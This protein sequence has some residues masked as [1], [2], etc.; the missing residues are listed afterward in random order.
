MLTE[1]NHLFHHVL[2]AFQHQVIFFNYQEIHLGPLWQHLELL[3]LEL[4]M[5]QSLLEASEL[6]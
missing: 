6:P 3:L 1:R 2:P 5:S 4:L